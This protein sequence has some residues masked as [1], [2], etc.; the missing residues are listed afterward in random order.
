V[1]WLASIIGLNQELISHIDNIEKR[2]SATTSADYPGS[3][4]PDRDQQLGSKRAVSTIPRNIQEDPRSIT[5]AENIHADRRN[6]IQIT[7][8][9]TSS[10]DIEDTRQEKLVKETRE[11][12]HLS[13][14]ARTAAI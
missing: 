9:D 5:T 8:D 7:D 1:W 11:F 4:H 14:K 10:L 12:I 6:Q 3:L 13:K 2:N